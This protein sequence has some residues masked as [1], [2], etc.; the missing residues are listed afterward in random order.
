MVGAVAT[1]PYVIFSWSLQ[2]AKESDLGHKGNIFYI[3]SGHFD[4]KNGRTTLHGGTVAVKLSL[5]VRK[6]PGSEQG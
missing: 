5:R 1:P 4:E 2:N 6:V 3:L